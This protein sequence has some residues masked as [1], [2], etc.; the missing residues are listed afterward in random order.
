MARRWLRKAG[1]LALET[2]SHYIGQ[3]LIEKCAALAAD[4]GEWPLCVRWFSASARQRQST[5]LS[6]Q[7]MSKKQRD[8]A[9]DRAIDAIGP[10]AAAEA[11]R[12]GAALG[13]AQTLDEVRNWLE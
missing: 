9:L 8:A 3:H 12:G 7:T 1:A 10:A 11:E 4:A 6:D 2:H 5:G 13:Y